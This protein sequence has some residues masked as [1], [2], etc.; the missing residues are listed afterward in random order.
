MNKLEELR[1]LIC[2]S[3]K[4]VVF[5]GA[6]ISTLSGIRDFRGKNGLYND[7][8]ADRIFDINCF[9]EEPS[10]YYEK[11]K[12]FIY[13]LDEKKPNV[14]HRVCV[15]LE[16]MGKLASVV[17]QN[18]DLLHQKAGSRKVI[19]LHG[20]PATHT[21]QSCSN[22]IDFVKTLEKLKS[23]T[24]PLCDICGGVL[25]PDITFF[26]E[27]LPEGAFEDAV[28]EASAADLILVLGTSLLVQPASSVPVHTIRSGGKMVIVNKGKTS[29]DRRAELLFD[30]LGEVFEFLESS[31]LKDL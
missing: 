13:N 17:T 24:V 10:I 8:D 25:K 26:G 20:T 4:I 3:K 6:G 15:K 2:K 31:E 27:S 1:A 14:I 23:E 28:F 9:I 21:C 12:E 22:Q 16:E 19:E 18:I 5:T 30:D 7:Y 11:A 29:L